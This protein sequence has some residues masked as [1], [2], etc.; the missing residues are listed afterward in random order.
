MDFTPVVRAKNG[1]IVSGS[2]QI[3]IQYSDV[4]LVLHKLIILLSGRRKMTLGWRSRSKQYGSFSSKVG[5]EVAT[6]FGLYSS[7][8]MSLKGISC[9][10]GLRL[11]ERCWRLDIGASESCLLS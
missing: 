8:V 3:G 11:T 2:R 4:N 6:M 9:Q 1:Y 7:G 5:H 10:S